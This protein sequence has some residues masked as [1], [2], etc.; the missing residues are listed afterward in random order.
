MWSRS[1]AWSQ[2][3][4]RK[5]NFQKKGDIEAEAE[6]EKTAK[7][8]EVHRVEAKLLEMETTALAS[9]LGRISRGSSRS[10]RL[11]IPEVP[12]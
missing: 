4:S 12:G 9:A 2:I 10:R 3:S 7:Q 5:S 6:R 8:L 1:G 11:R